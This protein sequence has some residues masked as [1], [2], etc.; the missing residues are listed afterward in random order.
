MKT[1][2]CTTADELPAVETVGDG[3]A[4][5]IGGSTAR[6]G[7]TTRPRL[8]SYFNFSLHKFVILSPHLRCPDEGTPT[9]GM[10]EA[11]V[12]TPTLTIAHRHTCG[13]DPPTNTRGT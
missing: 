11:E 3:L 6:G 10:Q 9:V 8:T 5:K 13:I 2:R 12:G 4:A 7:A 1:H